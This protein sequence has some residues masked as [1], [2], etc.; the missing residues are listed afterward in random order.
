MQPR[1]IG[2]CTVVATHFGEKFPSEADVDWDENVGSIHHH[3]KNGQ[4]DGIEHGLLPGLQD[5]TAADDLV[6]IV[7]PGEIVLHTPEIHGWL[8]Q[9]AESLSCERRQQIRRKL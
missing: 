1:S 4:Q 2:K 6:L 9:A 8:L 7:E 5:G 3:S